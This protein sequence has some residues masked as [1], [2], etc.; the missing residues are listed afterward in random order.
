MARNKKD[1]NHWSQPRP[2]QS[3]G[4]YEAGELT[5]YGR[6]GI[7]Y[8]EPNWAKEVEL[9]MSQGRLTA[10]QAWQRMVRGRKIAPK[11]SQVRIFDVSDIWAADYDVQKTPS[12][13]NDLHASVGAALE[14]KASLEEHKAWWSRPERRRLYELVKEVSDVQV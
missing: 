1:P 9:S 2:P 4:P 8:E 7:F 5:H 3:V 12:Q 11:G 14:E 6:D 13:S 10:D